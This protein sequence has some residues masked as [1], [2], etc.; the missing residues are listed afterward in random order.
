MFYLWYCN[1]NCTVGLRNNEYNVKQ[2]SYSI[3]LL[4]IPFC[5][6]N[7]VQLLKPFKKTKFP[8]W[9]K[10]RFCL[11]STTLRKHFLHKLIL[12][13]PSTTTVL[14]KPLIYSMKRHFPMANDKNEY[15]FLWRIISKTLIYWSSILYLCW[16]NIRSTFKFHHIKNC[17]KIWNQIRQGTSSVE[18]KWL[19]FIIWHQCRSKKQNDKNDNKPFEN[20]FFKLIWLFV[21]HIWTWPMYIM[22]KEEVILNDFLMLRCKKK[23]L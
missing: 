15:F 2:F 12:S 10:Q 14:W 11:F 19:P 6:R 4:L 20:A 23:I 13:W 3:K 9:R 1:K 8:V 18:E 21:S 22:N 16:T 5:I 17:M 7:S